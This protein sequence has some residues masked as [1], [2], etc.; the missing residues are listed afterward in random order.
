[1]LSFDENLVDLGFEP[2]FA[3]V[4]L[5]ARNLRIPPISLALTSVK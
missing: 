4:T 1:V 5:T 2:V 3:R